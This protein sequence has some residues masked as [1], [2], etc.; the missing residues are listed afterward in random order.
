[1]IGDAD[2]PGRSSRD[3]SSAERQLARS[4]ETRASRTVASARASAVNAGATGGAAE[5]RP[6]LPAAVAPPPAGS[7]VRADGVASGNTGGIGRCAPA[8][9]WPAG[10]GLDACSAIGAV[11]RA[12]AIAVG[13]ST[14]GDPLTIAAEGRSAACG[15][16][17]W[18]GG[19]SGSAW[20]IPA[21]S[22][23]APDARGADTGEIGVGAGGCAELMPTWPGSGA[24]AVGAVAAGP[25]PAGCVAT[26]SVATNPVATGPVVVGPVATVWGAD[27]P[28]VV[29]PV[30][31]DGA[32][33]VTEF[34][35][36]AES[37]FDPVEADVVAA[38]VVAAGS[39]RPELFVSRLLAPRA[40]RSRPSVPDC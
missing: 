6:P 1:M 3:V 16:G 36:R 34:V 12:L 38:T 8:R 13:Y 24:T 37:E 21:L 26:G 32:G 4:R 9:R 20:S 14:A 25:V 23:C 2:H 33:R 19:R 27:R 17:D 11:A 35:G 31:L 29:D 28:V 39:V 22:G 7:P 15:S 10:A 40:F 5:P 18:A 30:G